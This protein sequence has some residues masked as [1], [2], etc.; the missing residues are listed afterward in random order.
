MSYWSTQVTWSSLDSE[1]GEI[2]NIDTNGEVAAH[3][4][5]G[6]EVAISIINK[7]V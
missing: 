1:D 6:E 3:I 4:H 2:L 5:E 7:I